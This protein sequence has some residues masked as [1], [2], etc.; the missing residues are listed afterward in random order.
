MLSVAASGK[1]SMKLLEGG[2]D[3]IQAERGDVEARAGPGEGIG[4]RSQGRYRNERRGKRRW[5][6]SATSW[7]T[8]S[9]EKGQHRRAKLA[10]EASSPTVAVKG[11]SSKDQRELDTGQ[12]EKGRGPVTGLEVGDQLLCWEPRL[13][14]QGPMN[15]RRSHRLGRKRTN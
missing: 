7:T 12:K 14:P 4:G 15:D 13:R 3:L 10:A 11:E 6:V 1:P 5:G 2:R 9:L 8:G